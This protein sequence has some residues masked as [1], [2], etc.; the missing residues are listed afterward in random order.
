MWRY[1]TSQDYSIHNP[2]LARKRS[3]STSLLL[4]VLHIDADTDFE[5][6]MHTMKMALEI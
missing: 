5:L 2:F 6:C 3:G 1:F 4:K